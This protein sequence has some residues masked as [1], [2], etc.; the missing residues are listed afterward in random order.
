[1]QMRSSQGP[2]S[3]EGESLLSTAWVCVLTLLLLSHSSTERFCK[4]VQFLMWSQNL[5]TVSNLYSFQFV[6]A[7]RHARV[8]TFVRK[9][10]YICLSLVISVIRAQ[11][12]VSIDRECT[13][14]N[15]VRKAIHIF[16]A[17]CTSV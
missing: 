2:C 10:P 3:R 5:C 6:Y 14:W 7:K 8:S 1:M 16:F 9:Q 11:T 4:F 12:S 13:C 17:Q 15:F